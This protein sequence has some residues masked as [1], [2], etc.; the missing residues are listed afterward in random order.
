MDFKHKV[1]LTIT[2]V[3]L[4][5]Y[6]INNTC[7]YVWVSVIDS[8]LHC[9]D[10]IEL[11]WIIEAVVIYHYYFV[12]API[13]HYKIVLYFLMISLMHQFRSLTAIQHECTCIEMLNPFA[14]S[15]IYF[16]KYMVQITHNL[17]SPRVWNACCMLG[18]NHTPLGFLDGTR[19]YMNTQ[20]LHTYMF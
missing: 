1:V 20:Y 15:S 9:I 13:L 4:T 11:V 5:M 14:L 10:K 7:A 3:L 18:V 16:C 19:V 12:T 6:F 8:E 2:D 17:N